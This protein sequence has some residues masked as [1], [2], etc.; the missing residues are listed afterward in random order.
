[1]TNLSYF[2]AAFG[3]VMDALIRSCSLS[4]GLR[5]EEELE[6]VVLVLTGTKQIVEGE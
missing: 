4:C 3:E 6:I 5:C 2:P 1:V